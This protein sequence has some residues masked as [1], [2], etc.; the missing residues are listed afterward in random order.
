MP[1]GKPIDLS[2]FLCAGGNAVSLDDADEPYPID[3]VDWMS[4][5][6]EIDILPVYILQVEIPEVMYAM[7]GR[8]MQ[9][10]FGVRG[11]PGR[12]TQT[13]PTCNLIYNENGVLGEVWT[14]IQLHVAQ[15]S[16]IRPRKAGGLL[17]V[18]NPTQ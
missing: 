4:C 2:F 13:H 8:V 9:T 11:R 15:R 14:D 10:E 5:D 7:M 3:R 16:G 18:F 17:L 6:I 12:K 1:T